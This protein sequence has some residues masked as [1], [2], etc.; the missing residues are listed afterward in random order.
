[1]DK[2]RIYEE[3]IN[4]KDIVKRYQNSKWT[5]S[6]QDWKE[7]K[8]YLQSKYG[9]YSIL[10][11]RMGEF[12]ETYYFDAYVA[13]KVL[14]ITLTSKSSKDENSA[15]M[16][17]IPAVSLESKIKKLVENWWTVWICDQIWVAGTESFKR[18]ITW[19]Y[20][21]GT[22]F[23]SLEDWKNNFVMWI[24]QIWEEIWVSFL[25]MGTNT[26]KTLS[27]SYKNI[28]AIKNIIAT[29]FPKE[30]LCNTL[31]LNNEKVKDLFGE[32]NIPEP[33]LYNCGD[34]PYNFLTKHF[35][36]SNLEIF[37]IEEK[38]CSIISCANVLSYAKDAYQCELEYIDRITK[39]DLSD[40]LFLDEITLKNL[41]IY[42][43][44][45]GTETNTFFSI[46]NETVTPFWARFLRK[47]IS[48][49]LKKKEKIDNKLSA[50]EELYNNESFLYQLIEQLVKFADIE[51]L[52]SKMG[53]QRCN[54]Q[55][56]LNLKN[57]VKN[58]SDIKKCLLQSNSNFLKI[59][60]KNLVIIPEFIDLI[61]KSIIENPSLKINE[62]WIIKKGYNQ[63]LDLLI[64][65]IENIDV[66]LNKKELE[67][68]QQTWIQSLKIGKSNMWIFIEIKRSDIDE[69]KIPE[70]WQRERSLKSADRYSTKELKDTFNKSLT[71]EFERQTLE[72]NIFQDIRIKGSSFIKDIQKNAN[73][74]A[75][76]DVFCNFA[77][78][79]KIRNYVKPIISESNKIIIQNWRHPVIET[80]CTFVPNN[81]ELDS[82]KS[83][84]LISWINS[85]WK[86][87]Y[88]RQNALIVLLAQIGCFVPASYAEIGLVDRIFTRVWSQDNISKKQS[89]FVN[90]L[91]ELTVI[92]NNATENSL[93]ILDE[94][95][96][97]TSFE[98]WY[99]LAQA[100]LELFNKLCVKVLFST[101]YHELTD[102]AETKLEKVLNKCV[103]VSFSDK[104]FEITHKIKNWKAWKSYGLEIAERLGLSKNIIDRSKQIRIWILELIDER[105]NKIKNL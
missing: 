52:A 62:W 34:I 71:A 93:I 31:I 45:Y 41:E 101:H 100:I 22:Y 36:I 4:Q 87:T 50:V 26:F 56:L 67:L 83:I 37:W 48:Q 8:E 32:L 64:D 73:Y 35:K 91:S 89:T 82:N 94:L 84:Y 27:L 5:T 25:D 16:A 9:N 72:Y 3:S 39:I 20:T 58:I 7:N 70:T 40:Y 53:T 2:K 10:L 44:S 74:L 80:I 63:D 11:Y 54:A 85:W 61:D 65:L 86:S 60:C 103:D 95:G 59:I 29:H 77:K 1:M 92:L 96:S 17:W 47:I 46:L 75:N 38:T 42:K 76:L 57:S 12:Y 24:Y 6:M 18:W 51:R 88:I 81:L 49:P 79:S 68:K 15:T 78:I 28:D 43:N 21:P 102:Y 104:D 13:S 66:F 14:D 30:V 23:E 98:D 105:A 97:S 69:S 55:D 33:I 19:I 90:E 99:S